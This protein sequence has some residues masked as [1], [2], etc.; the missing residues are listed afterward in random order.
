MTRFLNI[1]SGPVPEDPIPGLDILHADRRDFGANVANETM[2]QLSYQDN[3]FYVVF[4]V[5]ALDHT[6]NARTAVEEMIRVCK[7]G[8]LV[9]IECALIQHTT[10]GGWHYWD[11]LEDSTLKSDTDEFNLKDLG[12]YIKLIDNGGER[13]YNSI[14]ATYQKEHD[15]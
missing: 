1:G 15:A 14:I 2:E 8:G 9:Y 13:R 11:M 3:T 4:C 10:S 5:N 6:R 12:F 7:P